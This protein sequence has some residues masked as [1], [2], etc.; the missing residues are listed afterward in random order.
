MSIQSRNLP[1]DVIVDILL[2]LPIQ[3]L[4]RCRSVSKYWYGPETIHHPDIHVHVE[5]DS[6]ES[7][8]VVGP[9]VDS[10]YS[11]YANG[12]LHWIA[13]E[14]RGVLSIVSLDLRNGVF[15]Q[16]ALPIPCYSPRDIH[17]LFASTGGLSLSLYTY[18]E[19]MDGRYEVWVM[20]EYGVQESWTKQSS[21][22][23]LSRLGDI[24]YPRHYWRDGQIIF[25]YSYDREEYVHIHGAF[26][27]DPVK[28]RSTSLPVGG[29]LDDMYTFDY[30]EGLTTVQGGGKRST[31]MYPLPAG[32]P[33]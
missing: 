28:Q 15:G 26:S 21:F 19:G 3:S 8:E 12:F 27:Y 18:Q 32:M 7:N 5:S 2:R 6:W 22:G 30:I 1:E 23:P 17:Q 11:T 9:D 20:K 16:M 10:L 33:L 24:A 25:Q 4:L 13:R 14:G 29:R 31:R